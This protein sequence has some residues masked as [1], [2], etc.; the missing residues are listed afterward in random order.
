MKSHDQPDDRI[1]SH[2]NII[3]LRIFQ[4]HNIIHGIMEVHASRFP[5]SYSKVIYHCANV[6][7]IL[8]HFALQL[9]YL[10]RCTLSLFQTI[11]PI[12][13]VNIIDT[14]ILIEYFQT[15]SRTSLPMY[16]DI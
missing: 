10:K 1:Q 14:H 8:K 7:V 6:K 16:I 11:Q 15:L 9:F 13:T 5:L 2:L 3:L 4:K 12:F